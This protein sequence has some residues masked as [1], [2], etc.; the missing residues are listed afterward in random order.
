MWYKCGM[1]RG[2]AGLCVLVAACGDPSVQDR[3]D[4]IRRSGAHFAHVN[5]LSPER[6][7][8]LYPDTPDAARE[9]GI[10]ERLLADPDAAALLRAGDAAVPDLVRLLKD[11]E[12]G[13]LAAAFLGEI[14]G[15]DA[16]AGL[17]ARWREVRGTD[18][19]KHLHLYAGEEIYARGYTYEAIDGRVYGEM[20][21]SLG[22]T[23]RAVGKEI[24]ADTAAAMDEGERLQRDGKDLS[25]V[26][27]REEEDGKLKLTWS[28]EPVETACE[29]LRLL[30]LAGA[31]EGVDLFVRALRSPV[32]AFRWTAIQ[33]HTYLGVGRDRTI[34]V[35]AGLLDDPEWRAK[36]VEEIA[37]AV[38]RDDV[39]DPS[40]AQAEELAP[41]YKRKLQE[42]GYLPR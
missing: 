19:E 10:R 22:Y 37:V 3:I 16:A 2:L 38:F 27:W 13:A 5:L 12:R 28:A 18:Q 34:P 21:A 15:K 8:E 35:L 39:R 20:M 11:P 24:A 14:G 9:R 32:R 29:G 25:F 42:L 7:K 40:T 41:Q 23:G 4:A 1:R 31:P 33:E 26:A 36:A 30:A 6:F 17:L